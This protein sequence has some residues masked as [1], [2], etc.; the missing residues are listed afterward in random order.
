MCN[1]RSRFSTF[2]KLSLPIVI[3]LGDNNS[4][5]TMRYGVV[6]VIQGYQVEALHTP[7]FRLSL[8]SVNQLDLRGH[9]T[10][11]QKG[12]CSVTSPSSC[13]LTGKLI[14]GIYIIVPA[15]TLLSSTTEDKRKRDS[16]P[17]IPEPKIEPTIE[18]TIESSRAPIAAK[19]KSTR[20]SL[21]IP[22]SRIWHR[23]LAHMN[24]I[25]MMSLID[26]YTH[27]DS[28]CTI[29]I[30]AKHK[31]RFIR[32][33][34][35]HTTKPFELVHSDVCGPFSTLTFGDNRYN[36]LFID[37]YTRYT[38][39]WLLPNKKAETC[40]SA[41]Q[42]FQA[43]VDSMGYEIKQFR[44]DNGQGEYDNKTFRYV[45]AARG[46]AYEPAPPYAHHKNGV[47]EPMI[48]TITENAQATMINSQAPI[49][50]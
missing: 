6:D 20:K 43:Q 9:T 38:S 29:C 39:V 27:N 37:N 47:A 4:V 46:T 3:E 40:T 2:K 5:T 11:F 34:V 22:E 18:P 15:T 36:I 10:I 8:L 45:L 12:K 44:C 41:Y 19:T 49:Q 21:T 50:L 23:R 7:T 30:Q 13:N 1:D 28:M 26:G 31:Q 16:S 33:P 17:P 14:N 35:K 32:V 42:S 24:P 25:A 48:R